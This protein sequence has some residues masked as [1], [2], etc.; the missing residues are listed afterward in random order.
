MRI[1]FFCDCPVAL[2]SFIDFI[3]NAIKFFANSIASA[4]GLT[5]STEPSQAVSTNFVK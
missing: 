2:P 5:K 3:L 4:L 1:T